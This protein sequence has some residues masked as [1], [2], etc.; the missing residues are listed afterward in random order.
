[1]IAK[2]KRCVWGGEERIF[3]QT[4]EHRLYLRAS[5]RIAKGVNMNFGEELLEKFTD[6]LLH[7]L[8]L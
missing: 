2:G 5:S 7:N 3:R 8:E 4:Q 6:L 1:M